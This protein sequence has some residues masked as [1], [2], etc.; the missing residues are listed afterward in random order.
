[1]ITERKTIVAFHIGRG[2]RYY[3]AGHR[4]FL[5][6]K[7]IGD[8]IYDL[9]LNED[10]DDENYEQFYDSSGNYVGLT[11]S[12]VELGIGNINI[13]NAYDTTY[14][15]Y[16]EDCSDEEIEI[17]CRNDD[18]KSI[19]IVEYL[20]YVTN[21]RFDKFGCIVEEENVDID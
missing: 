3:N 21:Y 4:T 7:K 17:I 10:E 15:R 9:F 16:I 5:G 11:K 20:K 14:T 13:D 19:E 1:M 8:F 12:E 6:E 2:G 18:Y